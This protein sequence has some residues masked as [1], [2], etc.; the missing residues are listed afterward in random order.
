LAE[1]VFFSHGLGLFEGHP[2]FPE[3]RAGLGR[4]SLEPDVPH[5]LHLV[6]T[7]Y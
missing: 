4:I 2:V 6:C 1:I 3:I 7:M 5:T